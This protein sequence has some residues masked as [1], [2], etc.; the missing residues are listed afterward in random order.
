MLLCFNGT[1]VLLS[2][3][4]DGVD[5]LAYVYCAFGDVCLVGLLSVEKTLLYLQ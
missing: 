4:K 3:R 1:S 2:E 5:T